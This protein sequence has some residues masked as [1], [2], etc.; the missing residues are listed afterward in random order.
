ML[1]INKQKWTVKEKAVIY[2]TNN[3]QKEIVSVGNDQKFEIDDKVFFYHP[4]ATR[5]VQKGLIFTTI[6]YFYNTES[7]KPQQIYDGQPV[8]V[9]PEEMKKVLQTHLLKEM[10]E[11][12]T[13]LLDIIRQNKTSILIF[14]MTVIFGVV[15]FQVL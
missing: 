4:E 11:D 14:V 1:N 10:I 13:S 8:V 7:S 5:F 3:E 12:D 15:L 2:D 9:K 6:Y